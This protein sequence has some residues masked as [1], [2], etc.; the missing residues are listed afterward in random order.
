MNAMDELMKAFQAS[1][2]AQVK[3][4]KAEEEYEGYSWD[5]H[6]FH[7]I[8]AKDDANRRFQEALEAVIDERVTAAIANL[9]KEG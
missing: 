4:I 8:E 6:G 1:A 9:N 7:I 2:D 5:Y 3:L